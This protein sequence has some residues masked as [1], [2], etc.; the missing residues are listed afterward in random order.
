MMNRMPPVLLMLFGWG[1]VPLAFGATI[2]V[3]KDHK[4][5]Q[6]A[7]DASAKG[8]TVLVQPGTYPE[9]LQLKEGITVKSA[10]DDARGTIGLKR[11][12]GTVID[13]GGAGAKGPVV[14]LADGAVLDGFTVTRVG[15]FDQKEYEKHHATQGENLPDE[16]GAVGVGENFPALA[17]PGATAVVKNNI[18]S[19]NGHPGIGCTGKTNASLISNNVV[20]RNMGGGVGISDEATPTVEGNRCYHN[21]RSGIGCRKSNPLIVGN[22][23]FDNVR[24]GVGIREGAKPILRGNKCYKNQRAGIG[25]RMEGTRPIIVSSA[26][27]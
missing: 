27:A 23:C 19:N 26:F 8:D 20:H 16:R 3:P 2:H 4:T 10:G 14:R 9:S 5:I 1:T 11:A 7:I 17:V 12:E 6:A 15:V 25:C 13:G 24:A 22:E 21:L 18:V